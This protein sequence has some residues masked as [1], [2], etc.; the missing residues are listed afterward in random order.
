[1]D[2][3]SPPII[4]VVAEEIVGKIEDKTQTGM[5]L[6]V[7]GFLALGLSGFGILVIVVGILFV[8]IIAVAGLPVVVALSIPA[9]LGSAAI[10]MATRFGT[11]WLCRACGYELPNQEILKCPNCH[12]RVG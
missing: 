6:K 9:I 4:P 11:R 5:W 2:L 3:Q 12:K 8:P 10:M 1:M 7:L